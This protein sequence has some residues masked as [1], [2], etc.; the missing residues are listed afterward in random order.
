MDHSPPL[1]PVSSDRTDNCQRMAFTCSE[2][3]LNVMALS[4]LVSVV[5]FSKSP[6]RLAHT[7]WGLPGTPANHSRCWWNMT[8]PG[9]DVPAH[10]L[11]LAVNDAAARANVSTP[12]RV[13]L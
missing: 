1:V 5:K 6:V 8:Q 3:R 12:G 13:S 7:V 10:A 2:T 11:G 9:Q 4:S